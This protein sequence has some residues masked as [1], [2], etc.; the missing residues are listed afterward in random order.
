MVHVTPPFFSVVVPVYNK[1]EYLEEAL[2]S[3]Y[4]QRYTNFE[5]IAVD[6]GS[7]DGSMEILERHHAQGNIRLYRRTRPGPGGYAARNHGARMAQG[8]W[9]V[10]QDADDWCSSD[11]LAEFYSSIVNTQGRGIKLYVNAYAKRWGDVIQPAV[12]FPHHGELSRQQGL[13]L[14]SRSDYIHMNG[15]CIDRRAF[16]DSGGFPEGIYRRGGD[17]YYWIRLLA[18]MHRTHYNRKVTSHWKIDN[19]GISNNLNNLI[20]THPARDALGALPHELTW[21]E[22]YYAKKA[23][24][25][26]LISWGVEKK[27]HG[28]AIAEDIKS[29]HPEALSLKQVLH[30]LTLMLPDNLFA[31]CR[32][33]VGKAL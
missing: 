8:R 16:L 26:K 20:N 25:R 6:D 2:E 12:A 31:H 18:S 23:V 24:N 21:K 17:V 4:A 19:C 9:L 33:L 27:R 13:E 14:F 3:L 32:T 7:T 30:C 5:I 22:A 15:A 1:A 10:F 29:L 11:H 28:M